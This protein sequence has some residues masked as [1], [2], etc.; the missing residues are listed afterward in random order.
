MNGT[1]LVSSCAEADSSAEV[2][3]LGEMQAYVVLGV[4]WCIEP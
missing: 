2:R 3:W 4:A 1:L